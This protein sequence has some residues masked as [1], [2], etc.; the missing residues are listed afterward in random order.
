MD[1]LIKLL[2]VP[3][4]AVLF[5]YLIYNERQ[6]EKEKKDVV[7]GIEPPKDGIYREHFYSDNELRAKKKPDFSQRVHVQSK[8]KLEIWVEEHGKQLAAYMEK[9]AFFIPLSTCGE[10]E[11]D[12]IEWLNNLPN[13]EYAILETDGI[14][15]KMRSDD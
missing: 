4:T 1:V 9:D 12:L 13:V 11:K 14:H 3:F 5:A 2:F 10:I 8:S 7:K 15:A 6:R